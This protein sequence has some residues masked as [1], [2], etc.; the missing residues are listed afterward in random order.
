MQS[1]ETY[2]KQHW[3]SVLS[4]LIAWVK[5]IELAEDVLQEAVVSA[6]LVWKKQG[7]PDNPKAWLLRTAKNKAIDLLRRDQNYQTKL[8]QVEILS[9][10]QSGYAAVDDASEIPDQRLKLIF[11]CA[12][13]ALNI[14]A[15][16][17][18]TLH[19][20]AGLGTE[21]IAS[22]FLLN[23][24]TMAQRL[25]RAKR[26]IKKAGIP[27]EVPE[28][29]QLQERLNSVL[30]VIYLIFNEGYHAS[31][32]EQLMHAN[33]IAE[34]L[35]LV[36]TVSE[37]LPQESEVM[38]LMSLMLFHDARSRA[39]TNEQG[40]IQPLEQQDRGCWDQIKIKK[41]DH[42]LHQALALKQPGPYQIQAAIS[43]LH[44][45]AKSYAATDW[46]QI[47][48]LYAKLFEYQPTSVVQLNWIFARSKVFGVASALEE[49]STL[50]SQ[51][52]LQDY[53]AFYALKAE[54]LMLSGQKTA[55][56]EVLERAIDLSSNQ[57]QIEFLESKKAS[58][59]TNSN[60]N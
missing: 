18:L 54:L 57:A 10:L 26:K 28:K 47:E 20:V 38:G 42:I 56:V 40:Q 41:A 31:F 30:A 17:A 29:N 27:Y 15:Q 3:G 39:R 2:L 7:I 58:L 43:A 59:Q 46:Q 5:D 9:Q 51:G 60:Q 1:I 37:L 32:S 22:A 16:V 48:L 55:A 33:L 44:C 14:D 13:P 6:L 35:S 25:V 8:Q 49:L 45:Q 50:Q 12:H 21:K 52:K 53:Q 24:S 36:F 4:V 11:T 34:A 23:K 19:T